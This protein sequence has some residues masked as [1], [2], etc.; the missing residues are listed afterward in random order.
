[1][2]NAPEDILDMLR[3]R[4]NNPKAS[5]K[6]ILVHDF[7]VKWSHEVSTCELQFVELLYEGGKYLTSQQTEEW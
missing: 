5:P 2:E 7:W 4:L 1:M 3:L 6:S